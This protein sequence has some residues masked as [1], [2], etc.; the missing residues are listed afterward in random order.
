MVLYTSG[1]RRTAVLQQS[2][3]TQVSNVQVMFVIGSGQS[4]Q[5][6][7]VFIVDG[8]YVSLDSFS[9]A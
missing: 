4:L 5:Q 8:N 9:L 6:C 7:W 1:L 2:C 3:T